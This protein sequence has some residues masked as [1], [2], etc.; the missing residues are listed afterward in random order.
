M[1][2]VC[3]AATFVDGHAVLGTNVVLACAG[4]VQGPVS[5]SRTV[6]I[7]FSSLVVSVTVCLVMASCN[8]LTRS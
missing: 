4:F 5:N 8:C 7:A 6:L 2:A 3:G 1:V